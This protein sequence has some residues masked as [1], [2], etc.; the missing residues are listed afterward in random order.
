M[1]DGVLYGRGA[2]HLRV[3]RLNQGGS[4]CAGKDPGLNPG[5]A[6]LIEPSSINAGQ[7][8]L[9][10]SGHASANHST[11]PTIPWL[12][13]IEGLDWVPVSAIPRPLAFGM[14]SVVASPLLSRNF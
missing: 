6:A 8:A 1:R 2:N 7:F 10:R 9:S 5:L 11:P 14:Q 13:E 3:A 4:F 12:A